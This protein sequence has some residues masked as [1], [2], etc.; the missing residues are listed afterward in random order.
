MVYIANLVVILVGQRSSHFIIQSFS[1]SCHSTVLSPSKGLTC[2]SS[3]FL[4]S[5]EKDAGQAQDDADDL[6]GQ[7]DVFIQQDADAC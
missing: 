4:W 6:P 2:P 7:Q 1:D 3:I 5:Q